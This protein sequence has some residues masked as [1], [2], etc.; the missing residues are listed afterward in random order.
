MVRCD[1]EGVYHGHSEGVT[2]YNSKNG[3]Q[4]WHKE[5]SNVLFGWQEKNLLLVGM[6]NSRSVQVFSKETGEEKFACECDAAVYSCAA[7]EGGKYVFAG[8]ANSSIYCF[9]SKGKRLWK[10]AT[11][12]GSAYSMQYHDEKV[13][14]VT[15][16]GHMA[17]LDAS[18]KAIA[19]AQKG[20]TPKAKEINAPETTS[21]AA[22]TEMMIDTT[23]DSSDGVVVVCVVD[24][25][26]IRVKAEA[27]G[28]NTEWNVQFPKNLRE[29][30]KRFVVDELIEANQ[31][32]FYRAR[33]E[34]RK[35][36]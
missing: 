36:A 19:D 16:A 1:S 8:D 12:C 25:D 7:S 30:G 4:I 15:T 6:G 35:L 21:G 17:C 18:E 3:S 26:Q 20:T 14:I 2:K 34:I 33:G 28:F 24:G 5:T 29:V 23:T 32:G 31:G 11:G 27:D 10:L 13:Y 22:T 9:D